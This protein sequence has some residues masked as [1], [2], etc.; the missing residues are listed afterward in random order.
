MHVVLALLGSLITLLYLLDRMG[1]DLGGLNPFYWQRRRAWRKRYE[2]DPIHSV[3][4]P[5]GIAALFIIGVAKIDGDISATQK[6]AVLTEF[7]NRFSLDER[8]ATQLFGASAH[9]LGQPQV[10]RTQLDGVMERHREHFSA[11]QV[12]SLIDM[13]TTVVT[14]DGEATPDQAELIAMVRDQLA[15]PQGGD[16]VW[17]EQS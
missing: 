8:Q 13:M 17:G 11:E 6:D 14:A 12:T 3:E 2:G 5:I 1:V 10:I 9:L 15:R 16:G 7:R 4:D